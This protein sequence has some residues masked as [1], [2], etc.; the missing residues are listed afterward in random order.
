[1]F[2]QYSLK[3]SYVAKY[4][5]LHL[6]TSYILLPY[7]GVTNSFLKL[8]LHIYKLRIQI[9]ISLILGNLYLAGLH[10][11]ISIEQKKKY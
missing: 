2:E 7:G 4:N 5:A 6:G 9:Q 8:H 11:D 1:M 3:L 10:T